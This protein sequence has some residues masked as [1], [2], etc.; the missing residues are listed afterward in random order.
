MCWTLC[1]ELGRIVPAKGGAKVIKKS[2]TL[3]FQPE[4]ERFRIKIGDGSSPEVQGF[5]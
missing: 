4:K 5:T 3:L 2:G 1:I